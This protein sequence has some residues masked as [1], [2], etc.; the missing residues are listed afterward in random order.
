MLFISISFYKKKI[1]FHTVNISSFSDIIFLLYL[2]ASNT[3]NQYGKSKEIRALKLKPINPSVVFTSKAF[4]LYFDKLL[5]LLIN[6]FG[7][8]IWHKLVF[9]FQNDNTFSL[10]SS[11]PLLSTGES[12]CK[13]FS[14]RLVL[15]SDLGLRFKKSLPQPRFSTV[16]QLSG[17]F[18][19]YKFNTV[20]WPFIQ[21]GAQKRNHAFL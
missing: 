19:F 4:L 1:Q 7:F 16:V 10:L 13:F 12:R 3:T 8:R 20:N 15:C 11:T 14:R 18:N 17:V 9:T 21:Y 6:S 2:S 5:D